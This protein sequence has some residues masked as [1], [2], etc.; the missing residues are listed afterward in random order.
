MTDIEYEPD[1]KEIIDNCCKMM[2]ATTVAKKMKSRKATSRR[3]IED[4][5]DKRALR[6]A[7]ELSL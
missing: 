2:G 4:I 3:R 5:K 7:T 6:E 1:N